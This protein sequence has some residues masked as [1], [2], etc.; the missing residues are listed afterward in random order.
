M[1]ILPAEPKIGYTRLP[2]GRVCFGLVKAR[3]YYGLSTP[4]LLHAAIYS[5]RDTA[6]RLEPAEEL[7]ARELAEVKILEEDRS[8]IHFVDVRLGAEKTGFLEDLQKSTGLSRDEVVCAIILWAF[9]ER[10]N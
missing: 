7:L 6:S 1:D 4:A 5:L 2:L 8:E 3:N 9:R 10:R